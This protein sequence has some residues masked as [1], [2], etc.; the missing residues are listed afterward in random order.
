MQ[1]SYRVAS[2]WLALAVASAALV[3]VALHPGIAGSMLFL[4][5]AGMR[6]DVR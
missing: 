2:I 3:I 6:R 1:H 5:L 4:P